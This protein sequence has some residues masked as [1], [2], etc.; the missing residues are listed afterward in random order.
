MVWSSGWAHFDLNDLYPHPS[1]GVAQS[2]TAMGNYSILFLFF[3][4]LVFSAKSVCHPCSMW[5]WLLWRDGMGLRTHCIES[6]FVLK[7][8]FNYGKKNDLS[9]SCPHE[10]GGFGTEICEVGVWHQLGGA[11]GPE[12]ECFRGGSG[13]V[14]QQ[15]EGWRR[16]SGQKGVYHH[17]SVRF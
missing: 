3:W 7:Y 17:C 13:G 6:S 2:D 8:Y 4:S 9:L 10:W 11:D 16:E 15:R 5:G 12:R 14:C 1:G